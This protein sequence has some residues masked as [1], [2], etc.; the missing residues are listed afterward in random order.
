MLDIFKL[1]IRITLEIIEFL[2]GQ[3]DKVI[4]K[5]FFA[6]CNLDQGIHII[7]QTYM[8]ALE[9]TQHH[10]EHSNFSKQQFLHS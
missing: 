7:N 8:R 9:R 3:L 4:Q 10:I 6:L 1:H 2:L 5:K